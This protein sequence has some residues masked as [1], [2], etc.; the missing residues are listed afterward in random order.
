MPLP[1]SVSPVAPHK[2]LQETFSRLT[3]WRECIDTYSPALP[4][5]QEAVRDPGAAV[6][7]TDCP[8]TPD[9]AVQ[10]DPEVRTLV[11][12]GTLHTDILRERW[13]SKKQRSD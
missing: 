6:Q 7:D 11:H 10:S 1:P 4:H 9:A 12:T 2:S 13:A 3:R 5:G 8:T